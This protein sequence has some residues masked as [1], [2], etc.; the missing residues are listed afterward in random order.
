[1]TIGAVTVSREPYLEYFPYRVTCTAQKKTR[2]I[3]MHYV[4]IDWADEKH[5]I[6][7]TNDS[8]KKLA[9]FEISNDQKGMLKLLI[10]AQKLSQG[11][12]SVL[13]AMEKN[14]SPLAEFILNHNYILYSINP[15]IIDRYRD[16]HRV[17]R[18]K[19]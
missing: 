11:T 15:K 4:G 12:S 17:F 3:K 7:I 2:R 6:Y 18:S 9:C 14:S 13:F 5:D 8:G 19:D 1:M 10:K 16:R